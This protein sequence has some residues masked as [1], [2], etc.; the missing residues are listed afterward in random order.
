MRE[1]Q[2]E[3]YSDLVRM[4]QADVRSYLG[5]FL[6][7]AA[8]VDDLAQ[9]TFIRAFRFFDSYDSSRPIRH[10]LIG[11]AR[12]EALTYLRSERRRRNRETDRLGR[13][14]NDG[15]FAQ[16]ESEEAAQSDWRVEALMHCLSKLGEDGER[17]VRKRYFEHVDTRTIAAAMRRSVNSVRLALFRLRGALRDCIRTSLSGEAA[18]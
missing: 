1:G 2:I 10:W 16:A 8:T 3:A 9:E 12:N 17:L 11:I 18:S 15:L 6:R 4:H 5:R 14:L 13:H 7:D